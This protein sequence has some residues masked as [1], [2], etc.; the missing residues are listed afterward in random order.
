MDLPASRKLAMASEFIG[1]LSDRY[2]IVTV[3]EHARRA[4]E[5]GVRLRTLEPEFPR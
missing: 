1:M 2:E 3:A 4:G 5:G